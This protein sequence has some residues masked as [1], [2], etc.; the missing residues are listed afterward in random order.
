MCMLTV[1]PS[2]IQPDREKL[3]NGAIYND[4]GHGYAII[5]DGE[6]L[7]NRGLNSSEII[8]EFCKLREQ[9]PNGPALFHSRFATHGVTTEYNVHPFIVGHDKRTILAHN[10]VLPVKV[11]PRAGDPR[12]DTRIVAE[13]FFPNLPFGPWWTKKGIKRYSSWMG[14]GNKI[15]ILTTNPKYPNRSFIFNEKQ[16]IWVNGIW[17][18]NRGFEDKKYVWVGSHRSRYEDFQWYQDDNGHWH[19]L[20]DKEDCGVCLAKNTVDRIMRVCSFC[21]A[22][23]DCGED[24]GDCLCYTPAQLDR[25]TELSRKSYNWWEDPTY[26]AP[27]E[28]DKQDTSDKITVIG[29]TTE[30]VVYPRDYQKPAEVTEATK[31]VM[32]SKE[33]NKGLHWFSEQTGIT[34]SNEIEPG[35]EEDIQKDID[36]GI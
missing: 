8:A 23:N 19:I 31:A 33:W 14:T 5:A 34:V 11:Q 12:S 29:H 4:D 30:R 10:G 28:T 2:G 24:I 6:I 32:S 27:Y 22:C 20:R 9:F 1:I 18:S 17:Y 35:K 16:G 13:D 21:N 25:M 3:A 26:R 15:A 36:S 7:W